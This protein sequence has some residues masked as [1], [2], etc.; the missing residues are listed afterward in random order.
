MIDEARSQRQIRL[1]GEDDERY[2]G[3]MPNSSIVSQI[4]DHVLDYGPTPVAELAVLVEARHHKR[5]RVAFVYNKGHKLE[6]DAYRLFID[7]IVAELEACGV[8]I[9]QDGLVAL[10]P[11]FKIGVPKRAGKLGMVS[12]Y[13]KEIRDT[14]GLAAQR[15]LEITSM[16]H[17]LRPDGKGLRPINQDNLARLVESMQKLGFKN[18]FPILRDQQGRIL[19]GR[20][21]LEASRLAGVQPLYRETRVE[22]DHEALAIAFIANEGIGWS[23]ADRERFERQLG[24]PFQDAVGNAAKREIIRIKLLENPEASNR[25]I[26]ADIATESSLKVSDHTVAEVR[27]EMESNAQIARSSTKVASDGRVYR[28]RERQSAPRPDPAPE[29]VFEPPGAPQ[30]APAADVPAAENNEPAAAAA[31]PE[32]ASVKPDA[33]E[34]I[35][36]KLFEARRQAAARQAALDRSTTAGGINQGGKERPCPESNSPRIGKTKHRR[37]LER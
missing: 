4:L 28:T 33:D 3:G 9:V 14:I 35:I 8:T 7:D 18:E 12:V 11:Q 6:G 26:A 10:N 29:P 30:P 1:F 15:R 2:G 16:L 21:R 25:S 19:S 22:S 24:V 17:E 20:H 36:N 5:E 27:R 32:P 31:A 13:P 37:R 23:K 34:E